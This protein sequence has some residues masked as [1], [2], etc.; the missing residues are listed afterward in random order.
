MPTKLLR[1][2]GKVQGVFYRATAKDMA[3]RHGLT[4]WVKNTSDGDVEVLVSGTTEQLEK[5]IDWCWKGPLG[6]RV[7]HVEVTDRE[8]E[9]F[10][11]FRIVRD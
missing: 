7:I 4:G 11:D 10:R 3:E 9:G 8:E 5:F 2:S 1:I 6:A